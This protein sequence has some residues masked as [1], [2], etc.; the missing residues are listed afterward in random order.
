M[1]VK[2]RQVRLVDIPHLVILDQADK[3][4]E[5]DFFATMK[6]QTAHDKV[7]SLDIA[8]RVIILAKCKEHSRKTHLALAR[9]F[10]EYVA[11]RKGSADVT[12]YLEFTCVGKLAKSILDSEQVEIQFPTLL[13]VKTVFVT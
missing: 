3:Q 6:K 13:E 7:H 9:A 11:S 8:Y 4:P 10:L 12:L 2:S 1:F 5:S